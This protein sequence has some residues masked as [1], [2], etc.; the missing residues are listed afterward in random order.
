VLSP[1]VDPC[2]DQVRAAIE[3]AMEAQ[4]QYM[5]GVLPAEALSEASGDVA[6]YAQQ[7][8]DL[9]LDYRT[10]RIQDV[11]IVEVTW[12]IE[13]CEAR[14]AGERAQVSATERWTYRAELACASGE[15]RDSTWVDFFPA[16]SYT[17]VRSGEGWRI[18]SWLTG[19]V[20]TEAMWVCP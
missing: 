14:L 10:E 15:A 18:A 12:T 7:Q 1:R 9:M 17:L 5:E 11:E 16:E 3:R 8:A 20:R 4:A 2:D 13:R 19:P 6:I